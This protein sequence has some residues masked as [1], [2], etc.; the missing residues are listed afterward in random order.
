V[1]ACLRS[2]RH[3]TRPSR[4]SALQRI[5]PASSPRYTDPRYVPIAVNAVASAPLTRI[6]VRIRTPAAGPATTGS[7]I[8]RS[9]FAPATPASW[10]PPPTTPPRHTSSTAHSRAVP[11]TSA[12]YPAS[13]C[14]LQPAE[15]MKPDRGQVDGAPR[16]L[17]PQRRKDRT[18]N[19]HVGFLPVRDDAGA[20]TPA[21]QVLGI[22]SA[23]CRG[24]RRRPR[25][26][27][28]SAPRAR[29]G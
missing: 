1:T 26:P 17:R 9:T 10:Q 11:L 24:A 7:A 20:A 23:R 5:R 19:T 28:A 21:R 8:R 6:R 16:P 29:P 2:A 4:S 13:S 18:Q 27:E 25:P 22:P 12:H 3:A 14:Q 15:P